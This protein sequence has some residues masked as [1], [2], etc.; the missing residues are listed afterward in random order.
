[1]NEKDFNK[2]IHELKNIRLSKSE[3]E[4]IFKN[5]MSTPVESSYVKRSPIFVSIFTRHTQVFVAASLVLAMSFGGAIYASDDSLPGDVLYS[6]KTAMIEPVL[7]VVYSAPEDKLLWEEEKVERR[8]AEAEKLIEKDELDEEKLAKLEAKIEKSSIAFAAAASLVASSTAT[9][10]F[11]K[12]ERE[13][14]IKQEF[15]IK[16]NERIVVFDDDEEEVAATMMMLVPVSGQDKV[17]NELTDESS[18]RGKNLNREKIERLK[19]AAT[20]N[21]NGDHDDDFVNGVKPGGDGSVDDNDGSNSSLNNDDRDE[22]R[23]GLDGDN[24]ND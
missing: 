22:D 21:L 4:S 13:K 19:R 14:E 24:D 10:S 6:V 11:S 17:L 15:K 7:D 20:R 23:S 3:K 8:I 1:M 9:S 18:K 16:I 12:K 5:V 2:E